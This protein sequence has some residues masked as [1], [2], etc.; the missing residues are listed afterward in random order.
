M[1]RLPIPETDEALV[2]ALKA[3]RE[4]AATALVR[5][6]QRRVHGL[7]ARMLGADLEVQDLTQEVFVTA[8]SSLD[9]LKSPKLLKSWLFGIAVFTARNRIRKRERW[10]F[11][12]FL[13]STELP[14]KA[15]YGVQEEASEALRATYRVLEL[16]PVDER[17]AFSLRF[18]AGM[19]LTEVAFACN[20]SLATIKRRLRKAQD[21]FTE[22]AAEEPA[23]S[24]WVEER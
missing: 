13:P 1:V 3:G 9:K 19:E 20:V 18:I 6:Y 16:L 17:L 15:V 8:L 11:L 2:L 22:Y 10:R 5:R 23:L 24:D 21:R 12:S 14:E 7:L 4:D